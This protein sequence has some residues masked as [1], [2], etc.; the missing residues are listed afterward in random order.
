M[1]SIQSTPVQ[2][3][4]ESLAN[5]GSA[6]EPLS[7]FSNRK[8]ALL[9]VLVA[10]LFTSARL[11]RLA[12]SCLWFDEI[13]SVHAARHNWDGL[14]YF[15][16]ADIIHPPLFY[17]LLKVWIAVGDES[18]MWLRLLPA[19]LGTFAV[20][21]F[22]L[23]CREL[24]LKNSEVIL[25]TL[26]LAVSGYLI[27]YAQEVRMY[28]LLF[29][30]SA[31]SLWLFF[32]FFNREHPARLLLGALCMINLL[33]VYT[34]YAGWLVVLL[35]TAVLFYWQRQKALR[36]LITVALLMVAYVPW[37]Y[38][39]FAVARSG[40]AGKGVAENIGWVSKPGL[41]DLI[42]YLILLNRPFLFIQSSNQT[43]Y[44]LVIA[45]IAFT[46]FG[47]P[48]LIFLVAATKPNQYRASIHALALFLIAPAVLLFLASWL[49]PHSIWG[50]RHLIIASA[51]YAVL[52]SLALS[53]LQ[54][55]FLKT[56]ALVVI[57]CWFLLSAAVFLFSRPTE[58]IWCSWEPLAQQMNS[59][60]ASSL[61]PI[62]V[63]AYE[64]LVAYHL[65]FS[66][67]SAQRPISVAVIKG[68]PGLQEDPAYFIPRGFADIS[69]R[70]DHQSI[71][72]NIWIAF[73]D[74]NWNESRPPLKVLKENGFEVEEVLTRKAQGQQAF[75]VK[76]KRK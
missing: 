12:A 45:I 19:L 76:L 57:G 68:V 8:S 58:F 36:F 7:L 14:F 53:R 21:P 9:L 25:A 2:N 52:A 48:L 10:M 16:A 46:L 24:K 70:R 37:I 40:G 51:P 20:V 34:H 62:H 11:W 63:Y 4:L 49:L 28:S 72:D 71:G 35:Q 31:T 44:N 13:F 27:K 18:L 15:V 26:L 67:S 56:T 47:L 43:G 73:R 65:W 3:T 22:V 50:T 61:Q 6:E 42:Q 39:V 64:D 30:L 5:D 60:A 1:A 32:R 23:L 75:L 38:L 54:P 69:L 17:A 29:C 74:N 41:F 55:Y 59:T 66:S 33:M